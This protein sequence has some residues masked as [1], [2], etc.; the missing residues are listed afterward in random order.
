[1]SDHKQLLSLVERLENLDQQNS[2]LN[3][4][5]REILIEAKSNGWDPKMVKAV[6]AYRRDPVAA[7]SRSALLDEYLDLL[8]SSGSPKNNAPAATVTRLRGASGAVSRAG[9]R[10][11]QLAAP[12]TRRRGCAESPLRYSLS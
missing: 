2:D 10:A 11:T 12:R 9:A 6:V 4:E 5:R 7:E 8:G 3:E 1:M